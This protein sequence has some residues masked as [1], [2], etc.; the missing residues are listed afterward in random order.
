M[1]IKKY[2]F[3]QAI[4]AAILVNGIILGIL[5][6][7]RTGLSFSEAVCLMTALNGAIMVL[8]TVLFGIA[9]GDY[10]GEILNDKFRDFL[11]EGQFLLWSF[12][13]YLISSLLISWGLYSFMLLG[14]ENLALK[15]ILSFL[16]MIIIWGL[17]FIPSYFISGGIYIL[18]RKVWEKLNQN[19]L[20]E[21][22]VEV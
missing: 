21:T 9:I 12:L 17:G 5:L 4:V 11:E 19:S 8:P 15:L 6:V 20:T 16:G 1:K 3:V 22:E 2:F 13:G 14:E 18:G 10:S 7:L